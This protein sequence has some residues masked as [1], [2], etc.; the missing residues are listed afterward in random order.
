MSK[1]RPKEQ[2]GTSAS[3][4]RDEGTPPEEAPPA[5]D[6]VSEE[7]AAATIAAVPPLP[8][9]RPDVRVKFSQVVILNGQRYE[10]GSPYLLPREALTGAVAAVA[11]ELPE[12]G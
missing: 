12:K 1:K 9:P 8:P 3:A 11:T 4:L 2:D 6:N 5:P 7:G 10:P